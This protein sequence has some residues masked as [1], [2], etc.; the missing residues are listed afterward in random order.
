VRRKLGSRSKI[1]S[2]PAATRVI[3]ATN[4]FGIYEIEAFCERRLGDASVRW[5]PPADSQSDGSTGRA[6]V[7]GNLRLFLRLSRL[8]WACASIAEAVMNKCHCEMIQW[9]AR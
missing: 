4:L 9:N 8:F 2:R 7:S 3:D 1:R 6:A 5:R